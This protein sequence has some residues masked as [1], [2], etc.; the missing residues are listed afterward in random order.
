MNQNDPKIIIALSGGVDSAVAAVLLKEKHQNLHAV[1][2]R[3]WDS[4]L[5]HDLLGHK[6]QQKGCN[7]ANDLLAVKKICQQLNI[8][9]KVY[10]F[11]QE[12]WTDVFLPSL[13][14]L[15]IGQ[16]PNP[17]VA[18]NQKIKFGVLLDQVLKTFGNNIKIATGHYAKVEKI[19][20]QYYLATA[21][22][23]WKDQTYFLNQL[24][25]KQLSYIIF[26]LANIADK[27]MVRAIA[28]KHHL[29]V[30]D[31]KDSTGICF[32]GKRNYK[33]FIHN[34]L[35]Y[36]KGEIIDVKTKQVLGIHDGLSFYTIGQRKGLNLSGQEQP[37]FVCAK[38][39]TKNQLFVCRA[40]L[41]EVYLSKT[42]TQI[43]QMHWINQPLKINDQV[44]LRFRHTGTLHLATI[45]KIEAKQIYLLHNKI[46]TTA[47]GQYVVLYSLDQKYCLGGGILEK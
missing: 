41:I 44:Y 12:Y 22:N 7:D 14:Q 45:A 8:P 34:Y 10:N 42:K 11:V 39:L 9:L 5:N 28:K 40:D 15:K 17:D 18:C 6:K 20:D 24:D 43:N 32:I 4:A 37:T 23:Q 31:K 19:N 29:A 3:N 47:P 26:P 2:M 35:D 1:Y 16:T 21:A 46:K 36:Q 13:E 38:D 33:P 30:W 27:K 25:Q